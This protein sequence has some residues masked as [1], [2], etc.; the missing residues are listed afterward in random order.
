M[1]K[2]ATIEKTFI[3]LK[4]DTIKKRNVGKIISMIEQKGLT[5]LKM[6]MISP[7]RKQIE[8]MYS[9]HKGKP[10]YE[11]LVDQISGQG[12]IIVLLLE[13]FDAISEMRNMIGDKT[14]SL[15]LPGT[16][17]SLFSKNIDENS[18]HGSTSREEVVHESSC[19][20]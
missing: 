20:F 15:A 9:M 17:R 12:S 18:I 13:G 14:P 5:I 2:E 10:F 16:I 7:N 1:N 8:K 11:T 3:L 6:E 4:P 19:F